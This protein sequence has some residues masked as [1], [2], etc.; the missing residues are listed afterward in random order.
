[1]TRSADG[2]YYCFDLT[3]APETIVVSAGMGGSYIV[4]DVVG[5]DA[6]SSDHASALCGTTT[7][8]AVVYFPSGGSGFYAA[9]D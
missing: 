8:D 3:F 4:G 9:F 5:S 6:L 7:V 1:M 2:D